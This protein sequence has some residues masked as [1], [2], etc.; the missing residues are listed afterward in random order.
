MKDFYALA[1]PDS[2][3]YCVADIDPSTK[4]LKH[5][6]VETIDELVELVSSKQ[7]TNIFVAMANF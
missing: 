4:R 6:F 5:I 2:G 7:D 3:S 1:L